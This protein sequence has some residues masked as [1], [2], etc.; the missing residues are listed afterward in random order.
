MR[1]SSKNPVL[2]ATIDE[3]KQRARENGSRIWRDVAERLSRPSRRRAEVNVSRIARYTKEGDVVAI[4]GKVLGSGVISHKVTVG[5]YAFSEKARKK[6][7]S[8]GGEC[9]TLLELAEK[10]PKGSGVKIME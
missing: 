5:A 8:S 7:I 4:P 9:L 6:I 10:F 3:L 2:L 1:K